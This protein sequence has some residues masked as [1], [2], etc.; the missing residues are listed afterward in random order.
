MLT[1][2]STGSTLSLGGL[3]LG[4]GNGHAYAAVG[5]LLGLTLG[6][7]VV[8]AAGTLLVVGL[9]KA[10]SGV[11]HTKSGTQS[12]CSTRELEVAS[13]GLNRLPCTCR[14]ADVSRQGR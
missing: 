9:S 11:S 2:S 14:P 12:A 10:T 13:A 4:L 6:V 1:E 8:V 3:G 5:S 7:A